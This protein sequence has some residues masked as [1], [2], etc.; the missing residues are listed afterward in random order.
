MDQRQWTRESW[1]S[2]AQRNAEELEAIC[3]TFGERPGNSAVQGVESIDDRRR[4][5]CNAIL[6]T[7]S[8]K[9][10][11]LELHESLLKTNELKKLP[12]L[13]LINVRKG[14]FGLFNQSLAQELIKEYERIQILIKQPTEIG[15][16]RRC[17]DKKRS[18]YLYR[19]TKKWR[20]EF[21]K[22]YKEPVTSG[23]SKKELSRYLK[24]INQS[25][26]KG[27]QEPSSS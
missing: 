3:K 11:V 20:E 12:R 25:P 18:E 9:E 24:H 26:K 14:V 1:K 10:Y 6:G 27:V 2:R 5:L 19:R 8:L 4:S 17:G 13:L 15:R 23:L 22:L 21:E 16:A 7:D